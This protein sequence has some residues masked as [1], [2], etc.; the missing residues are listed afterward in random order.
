R[1]DGGAMRTVRNHVRAAGRHCS[2]E[3]LSHPVEDRLLAELRQVSDEWLATR[4]TREKRFSMGCFDPQSVG[5]FQIG[6]F[7]RANGVV[8]FSTIW[9]G[10]DELFID[11]MRFSRAAHRGSMDFL[12][13][14][15]IQ[16]AQSA[17]YEWLNL[18]MAPLPQHLPSL[19]QPSSWV[20]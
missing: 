1:L 7:R 19:Q 6:S 16:W 18:G 5:R 4:R 3:L 13:V 20:I 15:L 10:A 14:S 9:S 12:I 2:F 17:G 11:L 8:V